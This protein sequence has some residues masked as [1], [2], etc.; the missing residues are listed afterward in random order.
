M[1]PEKE[2]GNIKTVLQIDN[3]LLKNIS[4]LI[5]SG[6]EKSL[7]NIFA[8]LHPADIAEI[9]NHLN[10]DEAEYAFSLLDNE[11]ASE[12]ILEL[13]ENLR[14][15]ILKDIDVKKITDIVDEL[16]SDDAT[17]IVSDLPQEVAS[18]VLKNID[19]EDSEDVK[20]LLRYPEDSAGGIMTSN[21]VYVGEDATVKDAIEE[22][23]KNAEEFEHIYNIYVLKD[24]DELVGVIG[25]KSL[26]INPLYLSVK[27]I[28]DE[29]LIFVTPFMD[30]EEV[31]NIMNKYDLVAIPVVDENRRMLGRITFDDIQ[32][33]IQEE[34][35]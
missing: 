12:V 24:D 28:L 30:Q 33:V 2:M 14:E 15:Q 34:A 26:L 35:S 1:T 8:D 6:S 19:K 5:E 16:H 13:D 21:F 18:Q 25:L 32:D 20:E 10:F 27:N 17:D 31:A 23:R 3:E 11:T 22:V 7:L 29:D 9:I 4:E